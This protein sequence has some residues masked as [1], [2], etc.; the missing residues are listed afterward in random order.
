MRLAKMPKRPGDRPAA[1]A[2]HRG[3]SPLLRRR[4]QRNRAIRQRA[5][6]VDHVG[7]FAVLRDT[8]K[9]HRGARY[10]ALGIGDELVESIE[11]PGAALA[12]YGRREVE[13]APFA[14]FVVNDAKQVGA[15]TVGAA[16]LEGMAGGAFL[17]R[18]SALF[19]RGGLQQFL[20]RLGRCRRFLSAPTL[21]LFLD[22]NLETPLLPHVGR[23]NWPCSETPHQNKKTGAQ[24]CT[25]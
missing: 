25:Q 20:D 10:K 23:E 3:R 7:A 22:G 1:C 11:G 5:Q 17:R 9:A 15:D 12:L 14:Y 19:N 18:R 21:R 16:L 8:R 2:L 6:I 4:R 13:P 24:N